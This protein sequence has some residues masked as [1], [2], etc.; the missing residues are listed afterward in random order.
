LAVFYNYCHTKNSV[1]V[2]DPPKRLV[3]VLGMDPDCA[4]LIDHLNG[5]IFTARVTWQSSGKCADI[6]RTF[7]FVARMHQAA[8]LAYRDNPAGG[9]QILKDGIL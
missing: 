8:A 4:N 5:V 2:L 3:V 1:I 6:A 7:R 9:L